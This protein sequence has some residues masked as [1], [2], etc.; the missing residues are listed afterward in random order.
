MLEGFKLSYVL[1]VD[2][3]K[4]TSDALRPPEGMR[5]LNDLFES[6]HDRN[7]VDALRSGR[8]LFSRIKLMT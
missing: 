4:E 2:E 8:H 6:Y 7:R 1:S 5:N 3:L